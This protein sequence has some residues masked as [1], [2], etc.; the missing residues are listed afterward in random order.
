[1][2]KPVITI[3]S[4]VVRGSV[5][6]RA[7][8]F[9]L[10]TRGHPVWAVPTITLPYHPG[11]GTAT[12]IVPGH[13]RFQ[14]LLDDLADSPWAAELGGVLTGYMADAV[15]AEATARFTARL[16][17]RNPNLLHLCD[18]VIGDEGGLYVSGETA[19]AI[20]DHLAARADI[21]TPNRFELQWLSGEDVLDAGS[22]RKAAEHLAPAMILATSIPAMMRGNIANLLVHENGAMLAEH[23]MVENAPK[24]PGDA[25]AA[26]FLSRLL[27]GESPEKALQA[28]TA[29]IFE[30]V[31]RATRRGADE[32]MLETDSASL[33]RPAAMV[34]TRKLI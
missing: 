4:H 23:R 11:H 33:L 18:P 7:S 28:T 21:L 34:S 16:K 32:L 3:S 17:Q 27:D 26:V 14:S 24:G 5:G 10:E 2:K 19:A 13:G 30:L 1:M 8:A 6:N 15:Q 12:R 20:R 22:A 25:A 31:A 29:S 9:A